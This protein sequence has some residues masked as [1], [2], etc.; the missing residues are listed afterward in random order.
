LIGLCRELPSSAHLIGCDNSSAMLERA[1]RNI[2]ANHFQK[3]IA[4]RHAE[5]NDQPS[6]FSLRKAGV[7]TMCW[8]LMFIR[9]FQRDRV[10]RWIYDSLVDGGVFI[11]TEKILT[12]TGNMNRFF[13]DVYYEFKRQRG[14]SETEISRKREALENVLIPYRVEENL[15]LFRRNGFD[16][17]ETFFQWFNFAGFLCVKK[18]VSRR[19]FRT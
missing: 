11:V 3:R 5:L 6:D 14:Y 16:M 9:P 7:V 10:I 17:A 12:N 13:I 1:K 18:S 2:E 8:T 19:R 4:V 15:D